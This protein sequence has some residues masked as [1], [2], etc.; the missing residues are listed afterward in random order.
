MPITI[1]NPTGICEIVN[2]NEKGTRNKIKKEYNLSALVVVLLRLGPNWSITTTTTTADFV[3]LNEQRSPGQIPFMH[4]N[5]KVI[6]ENQHY[7][8]RGEERGTP[9]FVE[10]LG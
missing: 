5:Q 1:S 8:R 7:S 10:A 9:D 6:H 3:L 2:N 4:N